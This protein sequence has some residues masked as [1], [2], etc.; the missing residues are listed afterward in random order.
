MQSVEQAAERL[1]DGSLP[2]QRSPAPGSLRYRLGCCPALPARRSAVGC[3]APVLRS[4]LAGTCHRRGDLPGLPRG[5]PA[6]PL[7]LNLGWLDRLAGTLGRRRLLESR[8][9]SE[10][11]R[12]LAQATVELV[13]A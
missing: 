6:E 3:H 1:R 8:F 12:D 7:A 13:L 10:A 2:G 4:R 11:R 9:A 5:T